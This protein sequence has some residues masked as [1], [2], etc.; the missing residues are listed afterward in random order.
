MPY[1]PIRRNP[2]YDL[3]YRSSHPL[4]EWEIV[5]ANLN[6][7]ELEHILDE[8]AL[9]SYQYDNKLVSGILIVHT[10]TMVEASFLTDEIN[11]HRR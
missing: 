2:H 1:L 10:G 7:A 9:R 4:A 6:Q 11:H 8:Y 3:L 5:D